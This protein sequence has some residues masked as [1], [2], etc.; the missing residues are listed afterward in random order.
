MCQM[1]AS[2]R[3]IFAALVILLSVSATV[4]AEAELVFRSG[5]EASSDF[6]PTRAE[7]SRFLDQATF[8][9][10]DAAIDALVVTGYR[11]WLDA[12]LALPAQS[13]LVYMRREGAITNPIEPIPFDLYKQAWFVDSV[14][15]PDQLRQ[16]VAFALS[17]IMVV[18][19]RGNA[20]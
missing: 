1:V 15:A 6:P 12:Q 10:S 9:G 3:A 5:F 7:A 18:S 14:S 8:G 4:C 2:Q 11:A 20:L 19:E 13:V 17:E 16:R